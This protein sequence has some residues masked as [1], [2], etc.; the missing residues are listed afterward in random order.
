VLPNQQFFLLLDF[1]SFF[2]S[3]PIQNYG[4]G[5]F[6]GNY[7]LFPMSCCHSVIF[8]SSLLNDLWTTSPANTIISPSSPFCRRT[9]PPSFR[10]SCIPR[11]SCGFPSL[12]PQLDVLM[13]APAAFSR[14][15]PVPLLFYLSSSNWKSGFLLNC[16]FPVCLLKFTTCSSLYKYGPEAGNRPLCI[17]PLSVGP[18]RLEVYFFRKTVPPGDILTYRCPHCK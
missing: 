3:S 9:F 11:C 13:L 16:P 7:L 12:S 4:C 18:F 6:V 2:S 17:N 1:P 14:T 15:R 5:S 8:S 10:C